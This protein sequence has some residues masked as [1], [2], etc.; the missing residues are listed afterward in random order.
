M[1]NN[2]K[3]YMSEY[4]EPKPRK[5]REDGQMIYLIK[6]LNSMNAFILLLVISAVGSQLKY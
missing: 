2:I 3:E 4:D 1:V 6:T 5:F